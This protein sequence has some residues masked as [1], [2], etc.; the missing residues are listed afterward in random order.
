LFQGLTELAL[1]LIPKA[2]GTQKNMKISLIHHSRA[3]GNP[4]L[5]HKEL[6]SGWSLSLQVVSGEPAG[7]TALKVFSDQ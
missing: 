1:R 3:G 2:L 5:F 7:M 6:D 4:E